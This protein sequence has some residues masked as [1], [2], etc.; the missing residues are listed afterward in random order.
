MSEEAAAAGAR[1]VLFPEGCL[2]G[3][4]MRREQQDS[5]LLEP[6]A[7]ASLQATANKDDIVICVGFT[8]PVSDKMNNAFAIIQPAKPLLIQYKCW[9]SR[10]EP[11]FLMAWPDATRTVFEVD[12]VRCVIS[13]CCEY[14]MEWIDKAVH[15]SDPDMILNPSAG[16]IKPDQVQF[17][18][19][20]AATD[21]FRKDCSM[22][23]DRAVES[24]KKTGLVK[25]STNPLGFDG[26]T[27][28][29]GNSY[30]VGGD[31]SVL[32]W[33]K[34]EN[35]PEHMGPTVDVVSVPLCRCN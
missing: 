33:R 17:G 28:W 15:A 23:M 21:Q 13:I 9:R 8:V 16:S 1:L 3:N 12:G 14:G 10:L 32:V 24:V 6:A 18:E 7:F 19:P 5:M 35:R 2:N 34:G 4:A 26:E 30:I 22:F 29:P 31:G 20:T 25:V 27:W 11:E